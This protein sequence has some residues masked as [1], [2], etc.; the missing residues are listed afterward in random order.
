VPAS[1][2]HDATL[3][4][5]IVTGEATRTAPGLFVPTRKEVSGA[6]IDVVIDRSVSL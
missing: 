6:I 4:I 3:S 1:Q 5:N 2:E